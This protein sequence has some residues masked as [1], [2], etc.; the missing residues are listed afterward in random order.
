[1]R[2]IYFVGEERVIGGYKEDSSLIFLIP[3][4]DSTLSLLNHKKTKCSLCVKDILTVV[5]S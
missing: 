2:G 3:P 1:M 5:R 4:I